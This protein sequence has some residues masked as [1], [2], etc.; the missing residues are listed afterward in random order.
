[1]TLRHALPVTLL[2]L[3]LGCGSDPAAPDPTPTPQEQCLID[4]GLWAN[5]GQTVIFTVESNT[6]PVQVAVTNTDTVAKCLFP[7]VVVGH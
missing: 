3:A 2:V 4:G 7:P 6:G 1:M 5:P